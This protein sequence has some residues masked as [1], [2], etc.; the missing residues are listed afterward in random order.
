MDVNDLL[1]I[2]ETKKKMWYTTEDSNTVNDIIWINDVKKKIW[3]APKA[4]TRTF[5]EQP[6]Q[7]EEKPFFWDITT[8]ETNIVKT[9]IPW[10]AKSFTATDRPSFN[11]L[12]W[13]FA[14]NQD[15]IDISNAENERA[16]QQIRQIQE[17]N[18][19]LFSD[20]ITQNEDAENKPFLEYYWNKELEKIKTAIDTWTIQ[21]WGEEVEDLINKSWELDSD[22]TKMVGATSDFMDSS[23]WFKEIADTTLQQFAKEKMWVSTEDSWRWEINN[24]GVYKDWK[25][26]NSADI[27]STIYDDPDAKYQLRYSNRGFIESEDKYQDLWKEDLNYITELYQDAYNKS[28]KINRLIEKQ[29]ERDEARE[30]LWLSDFDQLLDKKDDEYFL[31][32][33]FNSY[34]TEI[35]KDEKFQQLNEDKKAEVMKYATSMMQSWLL[36]DVY[37]YYWQIVDL[38]K[39][40][41]ANY[42]RYAWYSQEFKDWLYGEQ[43]STEGM[44]AD[45]M[46]QDWKLNAW[47]QVAW[48]D[49]SQVWDKV[50]A[51]LGIDKN[52]AYED[53]IWYNNIYARYLTAN[54]EDKDFLDSFQ[55]WLVGWDVQNIISQVIMKKQENI[56]DKLAQYAPT[57]W[58]NLKHSIVWLGRWVGGYLT[59]LSQ[60]ALWWVEEVMGATLKTASNFWEIF[61]LSPIDVWVLTSWQENLWMY[62]DDFETPS[63]LRQVAANFWWVA[64]EIAEF[65][66]EQKWINKAFNYAEKL[67]VTRWAVKMLWKI[68]WNELKNLTKLQAWEIL[69]SA[70]KSKVIKPI[71]EFTKSFVEDAVIWNGMDTEINSDTQA[72]FSLFWGYIS[73]LWTWLLKMW[74]EKVANILNW[75][76]LTSRFQTT[77]VIKYY[78]EHPEVLGEMLDTAL[79]WTIK[80]NILSVPDMVN[81]IL[82]DTLAL[83]NQIDIIKKN[84]PTG[85]M[86]KISDAY[87]WASLNVL[88]GKDMQTNEM[89]KYLTSVMNDNR[90][91]IPDIIK[92]R[93]NLV[94]QCTLA[95]EISQKYLK[96]DSEMYKKNYVPKELH[97]L[98]WWQFDVKKVYKQADID[99]MLKKADGTDMWNVVEVFSDKE[100]YFNDLWNWE[101][102]LNK[103]WFDKLWV[104]L[105]KADPT[106][107]WTMSKDTEAFTEKLKWVSA[108]WERMYSDTFIQ[109]IKDTDWYSRLSSQIAEY[110][111]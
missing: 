53:Y 56:D 23:E 1:G 107:F 66:L 49:E 7:K 90:I 99:E 105:E 62:A 25:L 27:I 45:M 10:A 35:E 91:S 2:N 3:V 111:C 50:Y 82:D 48:D 102:T 75:T 64:P 19:K 28:V 109:R 87:V 97:V 12:V 69:S 26:V 32:I 95:D 33:A 98:S 42:W 34:K 76:L 15:V 59:T 61:W 68:P 17:D 55:K 37:W 6:E 85:M 51:E 79:G 40:V 9:E 74:R 43:K 71:M 80:N 101:Y 58:Q 73:L 31:N 78:R 89:R 41:E 60:V 20:Y 24:F 65:V 86:K 104:S 88:L 13:N 44:I 63:T 77:D 100:K 38:R 103:E 5:V 94:W 8:P 47:S 81:R 18:K 106:I 46:K 67:L 22:L 84:D 14:D 108:N 52:S 39:K 93:M 57:I 30:K 96:I 29:Q 83:K 54:I 16:E 11:A 70:A 21:R 4:E 36:N 72:M 110:V 92:E